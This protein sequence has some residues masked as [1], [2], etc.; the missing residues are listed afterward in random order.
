MKTK[1]IA[2]A[3]IATT[4]FIGCKKDEE[5]STDSTT[6][7]TS[8]TSAEINSAIKLATTEKEINEAEKTTKNSV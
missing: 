1:L 7:S 6:A 4:I 8:L 5:T 2:V 3:L